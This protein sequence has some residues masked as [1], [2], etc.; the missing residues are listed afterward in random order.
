MLGLVNFGEKVGKAKFVEVNDRFEFM[1]QKVELIGEFDT[2]YKGF[3][4]LSHT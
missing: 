1:A 3:K 4:S 2:A